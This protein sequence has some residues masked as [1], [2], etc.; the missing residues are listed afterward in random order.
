[1]TY[2]HIIVIDQGTHS[3]R[4]IIYNA[5]GESI[6]RSQQEIDLFYRDSLHIEQDGKQILASCQSVLTDAHKFINDN[7]LEGIAMALS[8]QRSTVIAW[9]VKTGEAITPALS[10]LDTRTQDELKEVSLAE[11]VIK[12]KTGLPLSAHYGASK[13]QWFLK[14][15]ERVQQA[16]L[17]NNLKFGPLAAYLIFNLV[18]Q[19]PLYVDYSNAHRTLLWNLQTKCWDNDL[20][21]A[22]SIDESNLPEPVPS[23]FEYGELKNYGYPLVLVNGD[24]NSAVYGYGKLAE[25]TTF[26]NM[27][28]GAF[29]LANSKQQ[30][31]LNTKLLASITYS[32]EHEQE[33]ALEGTVNGAGAA[34]TWAESEWSISDIE[35]LSWQ[36]VEEVPIF[37]NSIGG[38]GSPFWRSDVSPQFLDVNKSHNDYTKEQCMAALMESIVFLL[39]IN[40]EEMFK[41]GVVTNQLLVAGGMSKDKHLCQCLA[42]VSSVSVVVSNFKEATSR[43]AAWLALQRPE[44]GVLESKIFNPVNDNALQLRYGEFKSAMQRLIH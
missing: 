43:G 36:K 7:K 42:N 13:L 29:V 38:L 28:T 9:N 37:L 4:A 22:F 14:H 32:S 27:G 41:H 39:M 24:Q 40:I 30:P 34:M 3:T 11:N 26:I 2:S 31:V 17:E 25:Q 20:L 1:M 18:E 33:Y 8:T 44:W 21:E 10:W 35:S 12:E 19:Q 23:D 15:D 16:Q 6:F 5:S